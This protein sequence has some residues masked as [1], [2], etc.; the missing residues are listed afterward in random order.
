VP[1]EVVTREQQTVM[2]AEQPKDTPQWSH[3]VRKAW[4]PEHSNLLRIVSKQGVQARL[5]WC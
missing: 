2:T 3:K 4:Q 1:H 5:S